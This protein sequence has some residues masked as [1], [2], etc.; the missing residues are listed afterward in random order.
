MGHSLAAGIAALPSALSYVVI[1][2]A[3]MPFVQRSTLEQL[4]AR[5]ETAAANEI[6]Q[7]QFDGRS[8]HPVGFGSGHFAALSELEGDVGARA[9]LKRHRRHVTHV[10]V[11]DPGVLRD[12]DRPPQD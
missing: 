12:I 8:G 9:V 6:V 3:D 7:P 1:A 5:M 10:A 2:L 4:Q 11:N